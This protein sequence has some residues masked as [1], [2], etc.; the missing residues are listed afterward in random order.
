MIPQDIIGVMFN[1]AKFIAA[2]VATGSVKDCVVAIPGYFNQQQRQAVLDAAR[3]AGLNVLSLI[4]SNTA[5]ALNWGVERE[6]SSE[7]DTYSIFYDIGAAGTTVS[8]ISFRAVPDE[9]ASTS[10]KANATTAPTVGQATV[11]AYAFDPTLGGREFDRVLANHFQAI[12]RKEKGDE[13]A[14]NL[15]VMAKLYAA[16]QKAKETLTANGNIPVTID[17]LYE[18]YDFKTQIT[19]D[20]FEK[21]SQSL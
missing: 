7:N 5:A 15:R 12:V 4:N 13:I 10:K 16:A 18:D 20:Q 8:L 9:T 11:L 19:R 21:M 3:L 17:F 2:K 6:F 14:D 1:Y